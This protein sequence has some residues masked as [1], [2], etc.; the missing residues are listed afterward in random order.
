MQD[1]VN[2]NLGVSFS[3]SQ[4]HLI[5]AAARE[6]RAADCAMG[7]CLANR[8]ARSSLYANRDTRVRHSHHIKLGCLM[9]A[10]M[11]IMHLAQQRG[12]PATQ[13]PTFKLHGQCQLWGAKA[14]Q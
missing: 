13:G 8:G 2:Y 3:L 1:Y 11:D 7:V 6:M 10:R 12:W 4:L 14:A 5:K 9:R